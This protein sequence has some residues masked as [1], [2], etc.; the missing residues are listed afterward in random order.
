MPQTFQ[1]LKVKAIEI[2]SPPKAEK[3]CYSKFISGLCDNEIILH[4]DFNN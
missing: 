1:L 4:F 3:L 2:S